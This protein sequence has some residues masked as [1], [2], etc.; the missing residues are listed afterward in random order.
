MTTN[1][2]QE[3]TELLNSELL[4][5]KKCCSYAADVTDPVLK[6]KLGTFANKHRVRYE[7]LLKYLGGQN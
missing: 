7:V 1:N 3:V 4:S 2:L 5:Y 6:E